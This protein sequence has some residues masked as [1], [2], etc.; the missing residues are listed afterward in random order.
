V[1]KNIQKAIELYQKA[2]EQG[3]TNARF[4]LG[5]IRMR[6]AWKKKYQKEKKIVELY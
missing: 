5:F 3:N 2:V 6:Q 4:N 1:E